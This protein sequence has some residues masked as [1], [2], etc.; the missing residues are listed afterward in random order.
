MSE[1]FDFDSVVTAHIPVRIDGKDYLLKE[2]T[3]EASV[4]FRNACMKVMAFQDGKLS[5]VGDLANAE[6]LLVA[7]CM[8]DAEGKPVSEATVKGW[9]AK[10]VKKLFLKVKEISEM[11]DKQSEGPA[12]NEQSN[13]EDGLE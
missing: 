7:L 1:S 3:G 4:K 9:P 6:I 2:A 11:D 13:T 5:R 10:V 12:K 8:T